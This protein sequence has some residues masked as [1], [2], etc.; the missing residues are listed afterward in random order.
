MYM[1]PIAP[2]QSHVQRIIEIH[3]CL[4]SHAALILIPVPITSSSH[5]YPAISSSPD[6]LIFPMSPP[7]KSHATCNIAHPRSQRLIHLCKGALKPCRGSTSA[8]GSTA[9]Q[10]SQAED[11][12]GFGLELQPDAGTTLPAG[13]VSPPRVP[14]PHTSS[15]SVVLQSGSQLLPHLLMGPETARYYKSAHVKVVGFDIGGGPGSP[16]QDFAQPSLE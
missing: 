5:S 7:S 12:L 1:P 6:D 9:H 3:M 11:T 15:S 2:G 10:Q 13:S 14:S 4:V 8:G 16:Y